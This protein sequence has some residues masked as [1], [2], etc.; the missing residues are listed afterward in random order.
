MTTQLVMS[1][2]DVQDKIA[3]EFGGD[4]LTVKGGYP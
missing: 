4:Q 1:N 2:F 3:R